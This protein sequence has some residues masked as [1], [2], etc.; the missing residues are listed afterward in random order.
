MRFN[1]KAQAE[2]IGAILAVSI[3]FLIIIPLLYTYSGAITSMSRT[4]VNRSAFEIEKRS[5]NIRFNPLNLT[6]TND[7]PL[8]ITIIRVWVILNNG[9]VRIKDITQ[10]PIIIEPHTTLNL[11]EDILK[12]LG[13][14]QNDED[15]ENIDNVILVTRRGNTFTINPH[16]REELTNIITEIIEPQ[17]PFTSEN[18]LGEKEFINKAT[19]GI[20]LTYYFA[21]TGTG[22]FTCE[23]QGLG[24]GYVLQYDPATETWYVNNGVEWFSVSESQI[25]DI[26]SDTDGD[27]DNNG[28]YELIP[29]LKED[30]NA[31]KLLKF[32]GYVH[33]FFEVPAGTINGISVQ[34]NLTFNR[35]IRIRQNTDTITIYFKFIIVSGGLEMNILSSSDISINVLLRKS[36]DSTIIISNKAYIQSTP[37][38]LSPSIEFGSKLVLIEGYVVFPIKSFTSYSIVT[39]N[40]G[41][42]DLIFIYTQEENDLSLKTSFELSIYLEYLAV[43]GA[44]INY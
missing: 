44:E 31:F 39:E 20:N 42:Y 38:E 26:T 25:E 14:I 11:T 28:V 29:I 6:I 7:S 43:V 13:L 34:Q 18:L 21:C 5:E 32:L 23:P 37:M 16:E 36:D 19:H 8:K 12:P 41:D 10:T 4:Y 9:D 30:D 1:K 2:I 3:L 40:P 35:L 24:T 15:L 17:P 27:A 22:S 33:Y